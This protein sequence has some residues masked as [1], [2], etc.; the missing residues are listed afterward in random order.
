MNSTLADVK[1]LFNVK[2]IATAGLAPEAIPAN[3]LG[4]IDDSTG[5][6][7]Q[8]ANFAAL[9]EK[10]RIISKLNGKN[11]YSFD[12]IEKSKI[13]NAVEQEYQAAQVNVW[14][15]TLESCNCIN[16]VQLVINIDEAS[17]MQR[18]GLTWTHRDFVVEVSPEELKCY[19]NCD[20]QKATYE[21]NVLTMLLVNKIQSSESPFY[22]AMAKIDVT[23]IDTGTGVPPAS[24]Q[25][26]GDVYIRTGATDP[27]TYVYDGTNWV[28]VGDDAGMI[29]DIEA[30]V[31]GTKDINTDDDP[32]N[33]GPLLTLVLQGKD[34]TAG[35]YKDLDVNYVYPRGVKLTPALSVDGKFNTV[36]TQTQP[37]V[38]ELG[39]GYDLRA[40]EWDNMN[41]YTTLNFY[42][43][44]SDGI[45]NGD[46]TYQFEN[47]QNYNVVNFEFMTD[48]VERNDGDKR[49]FGVMLATT[50]SGVFTS[51][52]NM[53]GL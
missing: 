26:V 3:T 11:Y 22:E 33:D 25:E 2:A 9:P 44:L 51:L 38:Y 16:G 42:P 14:E 19:C 52:K 32:D 53:L 27:G 17:L 8:P 49:L 40:E 18:D 36:F 21:N 37:L 45:A 46:L 31:E 39:A 47:N 34:M 1:Q 23:G 29:T 28:L 20:G 15:T 5:L 30:F 4:V 7:V 43:Q 41:Y 50:D 6:T 35:N 12:V 13:K 10:F 48:K 24:N